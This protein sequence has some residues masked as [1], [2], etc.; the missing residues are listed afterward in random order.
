MHRQFIRFALAGTVGF[1]V[2]IAVLYLMLSLGAG[3]YLGQVIAFLAAA[4]TTWRLNRRYTFIH[5]AERGRLVEWL[6]YLLA[7][8]LGGAVNYSCYAALIYYLPKT[9]WL[10]AAAVAVGGG[11]GLVVNFL[12]AR[13][14]VFGDRAGQAG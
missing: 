7:M 2:D 9:A 13:F 1:F 3:Y 5:G 12:G 14:W 10:P 6:R 11:A 8:L 4:Y